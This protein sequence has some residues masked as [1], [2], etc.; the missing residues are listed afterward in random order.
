M[1]Q[2]GLEIISVSADLR[3]GTGDDIR[4][5]ICLQFPRCYFLCPEFLFYAAIP[6]SAHIEVISR[7]VG[8]RS[9]MLSGCLLVQEVGPINVAVKRL[10]MFFEW[11]RYWTKYLC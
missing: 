10:D 2:L 11:K 1:S 9:L 3:G 8:Y 7:L 5:V 6:H 4:M